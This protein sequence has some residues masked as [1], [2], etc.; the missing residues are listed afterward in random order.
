VR[1]TKISITARL[2]GALLAMF[3]LGPVFSAEA[4][5]EKD[6]PSQKMKEAIDQLGK[7]PAAAEKTLKGVIEAGRTK[8]Q[9]TF[10]VKAATKKTEADNL[11]LPIKKSEQTMAPRYSPMGKRDPF[12]PVSVKPTKS[13]RRLD[14]SLPPI[15][16]YE[17]E[18]FRLVGIAGINNNHDSNREWRALVVDPEGKSYTIMAGMAIGPSGGR[19]KTIK[20]AEVVFEEIYIDKQGVR[21]V[22]EVI[23]KLS[24]N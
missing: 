10:G 11:D 3:V 24:S 16:R 14:E 19:V 12:Q 17:I 7:A 13:G 18:Q 23:K 22:R 9:E 21:K 20:P 1:R 2:S 5:E 15:L 4:Q 6:T 8:L